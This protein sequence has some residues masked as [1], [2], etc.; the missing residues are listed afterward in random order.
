MTNHAVWADRRLAAQVL[1][2]RHDGCSEIALHVEALQDTRRLLWLEQRLNALP[3]V[4]RV[5]IDRTAR[6]VR[7]VWDRR[8]TSLPNLLDNFAAAD[9]PAQPL[10]HDEIEDARAV[11]MH[12]ALKRLLVA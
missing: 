12:D 4:R 11:E 10:Q 5:A 6:R 1:R 8:Q 9:C 7:V 3:G 2:E